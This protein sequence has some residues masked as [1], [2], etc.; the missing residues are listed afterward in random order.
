MIVLADITPDIFRKQETERF[1]CWLFFWKKSAF[2]ENA[3]T[4]THTQG[5]NQNY[6]FCLL[7]HEMID[8][9]L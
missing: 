2:V 8:S 7:A 9:L 6:G 5:K 3:H 4:R 1:H